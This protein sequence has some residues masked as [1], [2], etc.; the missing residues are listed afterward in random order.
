MEKNLQLFVVQLLP[1]MF[2]VPPKVKS[3]FISCPLRFFVY[4][5]VSNPG[6]PEPQTR[7][8]CYFLLP[9]TRVFFNYQTRAF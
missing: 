4:C 3:D 6:F 1:T 9:E 7:F 2:S 8:F 5:S